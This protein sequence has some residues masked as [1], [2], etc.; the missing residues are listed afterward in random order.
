[1]RTYILFD[2]GDKDLRSTREVVR[3]NGSIENNC[4]LYVRES[5]CKQKGNA[6]NVLVNTS[7]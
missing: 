4:S 3:Q 1:M 6:G 7:R 2:I 5:Q